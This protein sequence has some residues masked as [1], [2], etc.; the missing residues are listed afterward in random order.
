MLKV[1][2]VGAGGQLGS[3]L[4]H[5]RP[6]DVQLVAGP[7]EKLDITDEAAVIAL[8][9]SEPIDLVINAAAYTAVDKAETD[10]ELAYQVNELGIANIAKHAPAATK[11]IH[12]STDFVFSGA[13]NRPYKVDDT[14]EPTSIYGKS[15][16]AGERACL[17]LRPDALVLRTSWVYSSFGHNFVKSML[18]FMNEKSQLGIVVDQIGTP[19]WAR[20]LALAC[21][22][23]RD[24]S[25][26]GIYHWSDA[27]TAS[28]YDF[29]IAIQELALEKGIL[30]RLIPVRPIATEEY[31][32][33]APRPAYSVLEK[34]AT[35]DALNIENVHW[36]K[37]LSAMLDELKAQEHS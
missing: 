36:R 13:K 11:V 23:S 31:P 1:L 17:S 19:T 4:Q 33:P 14:P 10:S 24:K 18:R 26:S 15:K 30:D 21:W 22:A 7:E 5:T 35:I 29:A 6:S 32:L 9:A 12:V 20:G 16:L 3:E 2:I 37:Q 28:W 8:F 34:R 25:L 27:G